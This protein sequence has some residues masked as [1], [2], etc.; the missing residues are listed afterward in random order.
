MPRDLG[1]FEFPE[2][3]D[4]A[5]AKRFAHDFQTG[6]VSAGVCNIL[7]FVS[8][9]A[10]HYGASDFGRGEDLHVQAELAHTRLMIHI[11][12]FLP[13]TEEAAKNADEQLN[14]MQIVLD[15]LSMLHRT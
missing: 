1:K 5:F 11:V 2:R 8:A 6:F 14:R 12:R 13:E 4:G 3:K 10:R 15:G 9:A 7:A